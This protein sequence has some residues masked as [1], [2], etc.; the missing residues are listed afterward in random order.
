[1]TADDIKLDV[2]SHMEQA[3]Q[4]MLRKHEQGLS[5]KICQ[6][7]ATDLKIYIKPDSKPFTS[8]PYR[9]G[10]KTREL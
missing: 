5:G 6:I 9:T 8:P 10:P 3:A 7:K 1:M 2:A 4:D